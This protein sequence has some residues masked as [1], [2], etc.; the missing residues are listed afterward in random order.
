MN[1]IN[2][3]YLVSSFVYSVLGVVVFWIAFV[4]IDK[5]TP[6]SLWKEIVEEKS[7][8]L[9]IVVASL[10]LGIAIIIASAIHG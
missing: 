2:P 10:A 6:Y 8:A 4:I 5:L 7:I 9:A 3:N 1:F